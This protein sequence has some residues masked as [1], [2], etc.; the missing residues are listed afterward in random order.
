MGD[1]FSRTSEIP[2]CR[3]LYKNVER[4]TKETTL[5]FVF[6]LWHREPFLRGVLNLSCNKQRLYIYAESL[7]VSNSNDSHSYYTTAGC[8]LNNL[9]FALFSRMEH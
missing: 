2:N 7:Y 1:G 3:K 5:N 6:I 9:Q 4:L 8:R